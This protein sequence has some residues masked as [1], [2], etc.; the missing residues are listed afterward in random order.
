[1]NPELN[2]FK[3]QV[4]VVPTLG[5]RPIW[6][7]RVNSRLLRN[8]HGRS[9]GCGYVTFPDADDA[10]YAVYHLHGQEVDGARISAMILGEEKPNSD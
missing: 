4:S 8:G 10:S 1:V 3:S 6:T 7:K 2:A 5:I 9:T